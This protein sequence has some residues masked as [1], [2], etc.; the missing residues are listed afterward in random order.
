MVMVGPARKAGRAPVLYQT[1]SILRRS[2]VSRI[3]CRPKAI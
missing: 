2:I 3:S 1:I